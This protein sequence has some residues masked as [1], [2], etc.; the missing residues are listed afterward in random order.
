MNRRRAQRLRAAKG[1]RRRK[2]TGAA[3]LRKPNHTK[4][5]ETAVLLDEGAPLPIPPRQAPA[6]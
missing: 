1:G 6:N 3:P 2:P 5:K 4:V